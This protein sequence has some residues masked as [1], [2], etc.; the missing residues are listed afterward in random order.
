MNVANEADIAGLKDS[1]RAVRAAFNAMVAATEAGITTLELDQI[2]AKVLKQHDAK[3]APQLYYDFP[4]ATCISVNEEAAH[5]I[6]GDRVVQMGDMINID[7][8][9]NCRGYVADM[10]Q[11]FIVGEGTAEQLRIC[12]GVQKAVA[13]AMAQVRADRSLNVI[14]QA[15]QKVADELGYTIVRNLGSHG[16]GRNIHEEPSYVPLDNPDERRVLTQ[17]MVLTI[18][19]FFSTGVEWVLEEDDGWT[20]TVPP[21][22]L[23]AQ[24]EHT[25]IVTDSAPLVVTA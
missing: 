23:V 9:A 13:A 8:S 21:G 17:G 24:F 25:L 11:S 6:P 16:V 1:G 10:G 2:G 14:G 4:G 12:D 3:S 22:N 7:V 20:L 15:V 19:P 18:E 5:G